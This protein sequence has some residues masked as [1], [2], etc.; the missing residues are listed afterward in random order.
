MVFGRE[1]GVNEDREHHAPCLCRADGWQFAN[2]FQFCDVATP[3]Q[4]EWAIA[5][6]VLLP[7]RILLRRALRADLPT[8]WRV[9]FVW[10][11]WNSSR[12]GVRRGET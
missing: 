10:F 8:P 6:G 12:R 7:I 1:D 5:V 3:L 11:G 4:A 9:E 2:T